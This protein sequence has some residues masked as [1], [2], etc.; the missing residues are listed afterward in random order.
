MY[1][2]LARFFLMAKFHI[3]STQKI[4]IQLPHYDFRIQISWS[5]L[6]IDIA[7]SFKVKISTNNL[8]LLPPITICANPQMS[9]FDVQR[10]GIV[11]FFGGESFIATHH[12]LQKLYSKLC[13]P[14]IFMNIH[15]ATYYLQSWRFNDFL[16]TRINLK[17]YLDFGMMIGYLFW[18]I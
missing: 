13:T 7:L 16:I 15:V 6:G 18:S 5:S 8:S 17:I 1:L 2:S 3:F 14:F 11:F 4:W 9:G 12:L 10:L